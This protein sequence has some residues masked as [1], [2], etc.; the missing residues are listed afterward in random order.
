MQITLMPRKLENGD[1]AVLN[2]V[3]PLV[4]DE[5]KKPARAQ[6]RRE[7]GAVPIETAA[8]VYEAFL[9]LAGGRRQSCENRS[10]FFGIASKLMRRFLVDGARAR[11]AEKRSAAKGLPQTRNYRRIDSL[12]FAKCSLDSRITIQKPEGGTMTKFNFKMTYC[13]AAAAL[14]M[15]GAAQAQTLQTTIPFA[16][17]AGN[18]YYPSGEYRVH[19]D[20]VLH[21]VT[22]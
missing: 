19:V 1:Q 15:V 18:E 4:Y 12:F 10:H 21:R 6:L 17:T 9:K 5:L 2:A 16:F 20:P 3:I 8:L 13:I 14:F 7:G 11:A 22:G